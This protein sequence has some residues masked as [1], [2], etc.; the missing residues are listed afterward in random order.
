MA[1]GSQF[2]GTPT[3]AE[4]LANENTLW[5]SICKRV[6]YTL[7]V[8]LP[9]KIVAFDPVKQWAT[10]ELQITENV[11]INQLV[12]VMPIPQLNDVLVLLPGDNEWCITFPSL[13]GAECLVCFADMCIN[14]WATSGGIQN[15]EVTRRHDLSD[16]FAILSPR[17][18]PK[19]IPNYSTTALEIRSMDGLVKI[20]LASA[21]LQLTGPAAVPSSTPS[22][23]SLSVTVN[24]VPYW[25]KLSDTP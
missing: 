11:I 19:A 16:G 15:Q 21:G 7:R 17:S 20:G 8:A 13:I 1:N 24:N 25:L 4:R 14:A 18:K 10:V 6:A 2:V 5:K 22:N 9:G 23:F 3:I 12:T